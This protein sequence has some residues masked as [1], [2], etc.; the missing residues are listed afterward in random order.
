MAAPTAM[1]TTPA[2]VSTRIGPCTTPLTLNRPFIVLPRHSA[3]FGQVTF[4]CKRSLPTIDR[5]MSMRLLRASET[6]DELRS[7]EFVLESIWDNTPREGSTMKPCRMKQ[8]PCVYSIDAIDPPDPYYGS[9]V[10]Y[11]KGT[12][13]QKRVHLPSLGEMIDEIMDLEER[14]R[15]IAAEGMM[16]FMDNVFTL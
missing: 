2:Y 14:D 5:E 4:Q 11:P 15:H 3:E 1:M 13:K 10:H 6:A 16:M 8:Q 12:K 9:I 7:T